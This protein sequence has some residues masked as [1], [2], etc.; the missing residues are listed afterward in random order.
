MVTTTK[1]SELARVS[2]IN[3]NLDLV[4]DEFVLPSGKVTNYLTPYSG[5]T[6]EVL[7]KATLTFD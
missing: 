2:I 4:Y 1:G 5:I 6:K 7:D 3:Y